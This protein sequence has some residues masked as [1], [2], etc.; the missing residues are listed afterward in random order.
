MKRLICMIPVRKGSER[1]TGKALRKIG[2]TTLIE[3]A[4]SLSLSF[5]NP[6][7]IY[8]NTNW[9]QLSEIASKHKI[10]FYSR[11]DELAN[12]SATNDEFMNDF[13]LNNECHRIIQL[14]PTSPF[15]TK[16]EL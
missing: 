12:S 8:L 3:Q 5:F 1:V 14:L 6:E 10:N 13:L 7:D 11:R 4:I 2:D 16:N 9:Q 15:V